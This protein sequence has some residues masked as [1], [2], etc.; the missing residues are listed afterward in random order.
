MEERGTLDWGTGSNGWCPPGPAAGL[1]TLQPAGDGLQQP[2]TDTDV[3]AVAA[4]LWFAMNS[5]LRTIL[6]RA[7]KVFGQPACV[8][9]YSRAAA[10]SPQVCSC[11]PA[12]PV[13]ESERLTR[14][15]R[16]ALG[17]ASGIFFNEDSQSGAVKFFKKFLFLFLIIQ[18]TTARAT[19]E[20]NTG[21]WLIVWL[22]I[23][24]YYC[25]QAASQ[26]ACV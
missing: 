2:C 12:S 23:S 24:T 3:P 21:S 5:R 25:G 13:R 10:G 15:D 19:A 11:C 16:D 17:G 8:L 1:M 4:L 20:R 18:N 9:H 7:R 26:V 6:Q 22:N 14:V